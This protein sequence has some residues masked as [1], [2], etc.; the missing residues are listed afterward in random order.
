MNKLAAEKIAQEYYNL[1]MQLA[2]EKIAN[3]LVADAVKG[4]SGLAKGGRRATKVLSK[5]FPA[6]RHYGPNQFS[7]MHGR[8]GAFNL[9]EFN[10]L[11][12]A[13]TRGRARGL[14]RVCLLYTSPSPRD[15]TLS[16]MPSSA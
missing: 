2:F 7:G 12:A 1:G 5:P 6:R 14:S 4:L 13:P 8:P 9:A 16:R 15:A 11:Q 10:Q 3:P